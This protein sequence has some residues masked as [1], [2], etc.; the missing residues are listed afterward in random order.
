[1]NEPDERP[2][3]DAGA[4]V[5]I[6]LPVRD[7]AEV[8]ERS[9]RR[10]HA[11]LHESLG[12]RWKVTIADSGSRDDTLAIAE[13]LAAGL[14]HLEVIHLAEAGR[15]RALRSAWSRS[16]ADV[17]AYMDVD[18]STDLAALRPLL[19][20]VLD[21]RAGIAIGSRLAPGATV[22]RG[23]KREALSRGYNRLLRLAFR[24][25]VTDAQCG[26]KAMRGDVARSLL[27]HVEDEG[28]FFDTELLLLAERNGVAIVEL[29]VHWEDDS[30]T[31]V[32]VP[33]TVRDDLLGI[34]RMVRRFARGGG[35][36]DVAGP[37]SGRP[38]PG[39]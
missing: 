29:P 7:E 34:A 14:D 21:G 4:L 17:L 27:A 5:E 37:A 23:V 6:V 35:R 12:Q 22:H 1:M 25:R 28:W 3:P 9:V 16:D 19:A 39:R 36:V 8:L 32:H 30:D 38:G 11:H 26:F 15:G 31:R 18:L 2:V 33:T 13:R 24:T 20:P 10:L